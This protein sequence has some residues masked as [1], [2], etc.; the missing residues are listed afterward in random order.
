MD[1]R[2]L[3]LEREGVAVEVDGSGRE[4]LDPLEHGRGTGDQHLVGEDLRL[5]GHRAG[6]GLA[7]DLRHHR[8]ALRVLPLEL[9]PDRVGLDRDHLQA[10]RQQHV[11]RCEV[12]GGGPF[13]LVGDRSTWTLT[14]KGLSSRTGLL[15]AAQ[16]HLHGP[17][18]VED[19]EAAR[20]VVADARLDEPLRLRRP[21]LQRGAE[22]EA[23]GDAQ[24]EQRA[25]P[26]C[27]GRSLMPSLP[28][29]RGPSPGTCRGCC[30]GSCRRGR[31]SSRRRS[32][33]R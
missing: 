9:D 15:V 32:R 17:H 16:A 19:D 14:W 4:R 29:D 3:D 10:V 26:R 22:P 33:P 30:A 20:P 21:V 13:R 7:D 12:D 28:A 24:G 25:G 1:H 5:P 18:R 8:H 31:G 11:L 2:H 6:R 27:A 23:D